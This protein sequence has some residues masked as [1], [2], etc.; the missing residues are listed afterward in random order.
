MKKKQQTKS[1]I[2]EIKGKKKYIKTENLNEL[3]S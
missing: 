2:W 1:K 3:F